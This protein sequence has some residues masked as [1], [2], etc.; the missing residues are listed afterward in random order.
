[1]GPKWLKMA[2]KWLP[3]GSPEASPEEVQNGGPYFAP[4]ALASRREAI[5]QNLAIME[6]E[7]R[8]SERRKH[9]KRMMECK[10]C[11][12]IMESWRAAST[13]SE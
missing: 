4:N 8:E 13:A 9:C 2:P 6:R 10:H 3:N 1:M 5:F 7:A 12:R 11:K